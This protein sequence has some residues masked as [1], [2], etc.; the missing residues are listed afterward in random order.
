MTKIY[1]IKIFQFKNKVEIYWG[2][3]Q[4]FT[5][6]MLERIKINYLGQCVLISLNIYQNNK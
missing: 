1:Y 3:K 5:L 4:N 2:L 6:L